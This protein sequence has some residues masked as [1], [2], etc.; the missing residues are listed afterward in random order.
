MPANIQSKDQLP[1]VLPRPPARPRIVGIEPKTYP[2]Q[3]VLE[4]LIL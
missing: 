3:Y 4:S 2:Q 1:L